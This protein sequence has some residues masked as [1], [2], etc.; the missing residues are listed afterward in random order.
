MG[1]WPELPANRAVKSLVAIQ[2]GPG[3]PT[4]IEVRVPGARAEPS[5]RRD[6][7]DPSDHGDDS[8]CTN[9]ETPPSNQS[10]FDDLV[11]AAQ[12]APALSH[13]LGGWHPFPMAYEGPERAERSHVAV[14]P[15][16]HG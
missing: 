11:T 6:T 9:W 15:M 14:S 12:Q 13:Y 3:I 7:D 4:R 2:Q 1:G 10:T 16:P 5:H 8:I